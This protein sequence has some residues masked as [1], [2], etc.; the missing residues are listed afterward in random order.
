MINQEQREKIFP[1]LCKRTQD[2][3]KSG[4]DIFWMVDF[5]DE[6]QIFSYTYYEMI[7]QINSWSGFVQD[8]WSIA[9][10]LKVFDDYWDCLDYF[11]TKRQEIR[12]AY[13]AEAQLASEDSH[14]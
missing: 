5:A 13:E 14:V 2:R 9:Y 6:P 10:D 11:N 7:E 4:A 8:D 3:I 1:T 12:D